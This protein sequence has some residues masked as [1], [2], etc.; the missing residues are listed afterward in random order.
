MLWIE[1]QGQKYLFGGDSLDED[2]FI[3]TEDQYLHF[4]ESFAHYF[5]G[6][7]VAQHNTYI[8]GREDIT[9]LKPYQDPFV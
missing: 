9:I 5:P 2:G 6:F 4:K 1:F 8:G 7:G 3:A